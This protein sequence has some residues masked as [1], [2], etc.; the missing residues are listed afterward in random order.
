MSPGKMLQKVS[1]FFSVHTTDILGTSRLKHI[2]L[3]RQCLMWA[4]RKHTA[5]SFESI[6]DFLSRDHS[7]VLHGCRKVE[8][9]IQK[10]QLEDFAKEFSSLSEDSR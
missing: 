1:R 5:L 8:K 10:G 4:M 7:T 3:A 2:A 6:G 9:L